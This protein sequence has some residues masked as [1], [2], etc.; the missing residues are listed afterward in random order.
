MV[1]GYTVMAATE[2][3]VFVNGDTLEEYIAERL[4]EGLERKRAE[5][6]CPVCGVL[7]GPFDDGTIMCF[8]CGREFGRDRLT[9]RD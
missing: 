7:P 5:V 8:F 1:C 9:R 4:R 2:T 6:A 3:V